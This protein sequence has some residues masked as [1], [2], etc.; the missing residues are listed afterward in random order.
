MLIRI[1]SIRAFVY[2]IFNRN[3]INSLMACNLMLYVDTQLF[4]FTDNYKITHI[5]SRRTREETLEQFSGM[6][7]CK[8]NLPS[9]IK[10]IFMVN[11]I[12]YF[13]Y[14]LMVISRK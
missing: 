8:S 1:P 7:S 13:S 9:N 12:V 4:A 10:I 2:V 11:T 5:Y 6:Y 3:E 14:L